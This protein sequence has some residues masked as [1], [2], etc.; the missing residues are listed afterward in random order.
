MLL[1][2]LETLLQHAQAAMCRNS[3][4]GFAV[5]RLRLDAVARFLGE[6]PRTIFGQDDG[7]APQTVVNFVPRFAPMNPRLMEIYDRVEDHLGALHA[8]LTKARIRGGVVP[9]DTSYWGDSPV[10]RGWKTAEALCLDDDGCC[11]PPSPYRFTFLLERALETA[12]EVRAFGGDCWPLSR[13]ETQSSSQ[14][15]ARPTSGN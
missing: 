13:K 10:R 9:F 12:G 7:A 11:C 15:C 8:C 4:E 5:A 2:Y 3:N 1:A 6:R 14:R